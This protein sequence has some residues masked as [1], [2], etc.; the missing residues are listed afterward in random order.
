M[1]VNTET[2]NWPR[3]I[4]WTEE[5]LVLNG[6]SILHPLILRF[7]DHSGRGG[8][9]NIRASVMD[10]HKEIV[11]SGHSRTVAHPNSK[12]FMTA[13][14]RDVKTQ[15]RQNFSMAKGVG[16][17]VP[18]LTEELFAIDSCG[19]GTVS[20]LCDPGRSY[21]SGRPHIQES[22]DS[23]NRTWFFF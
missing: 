17:K 9:K 12:H 7:R 8:G 20:F 10:N 5:F 18:P 1:V 6:T 14:T 19:R 15:A 11:S 23:T 22:L 16:H 3:F 2:F 4:E 21:P 13:C